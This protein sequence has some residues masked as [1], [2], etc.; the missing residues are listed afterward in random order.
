[1]TLT[2]EQIER[3]CSQVGL[4]H[5][6]RLELHRQLS[7]FGVKPAA[8]VPTNEGIIKAVAEKR[9]PWNALT[10]IA[11]AEIDPGSIPRLNALKGSLRHFGYALEP[12][13]AV[14][15]IA[16]QKCLDSRNTA[17]DV[18]LKWTLKTEMRRLGLLPRH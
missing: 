6:Q 15:P 13:K 4:R 14:D 9:S 12:D 7:E 5:D 11:C 8:E 1:M 2:T 18:D 16:L 10:P 3:I 17:H